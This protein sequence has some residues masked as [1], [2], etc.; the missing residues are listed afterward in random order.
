M[1]KILFEDMSPAELAEEIRMT[2][3]V[4]LPVGSME[5]H[6]PHLGMGTDTL[7]A[8]AVALEVSKTIG[9]VVFPPLYIGTE[10]YRKPESLVRIG[11]HED[12]K[13]IGMDF[14]KNLFKSMYWPPE[15]FETILETQIQMLCR[16]GFR[17]VVIL[18][19]HAAPIQKEILERLGEKL[20]VEKQTQVMPITV[21]F[22]GC[23]AGLGH[24]GLVETAVMQYVRKDSVRLDA[25]PPKPHKLYYLD[26]GIADGGGS[27]TDFSVRYDPRDATAELGKKVTDY[28]VK[29]C[30]ELILEAQ[31]RL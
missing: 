9:G 21:L 13:I 22:P 30:A 27:D 18:N 11:F 26:W 7:N 14:P 17:Q 1:K 20:S 4:Y 8:H 24:A 28:A 25:L 2:G 19:G 6:G 3:R 31:K 29:Q 16:M 5:W 23:G 15:L 12:D 10:T